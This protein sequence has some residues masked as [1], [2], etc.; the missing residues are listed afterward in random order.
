MELERRLTK[1]GVESVLNDLTVRESDRVHFQKILD[2]RA[3]GRNIVHV[4]NKEG[5]LVTYNGKMEKLKKSTNK[6]KVSYWS[7][8]GSYVEDAEDLDMSVYALAVDLLFGDLVL[9]D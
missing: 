5:K 6:Y 4:W 7:Q 8:E 1:S 2:G 9:S 3:V